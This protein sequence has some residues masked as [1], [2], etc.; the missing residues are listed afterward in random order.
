MRAVDADAQ[1]AVE[2]AG[3]RRRHRVIDEP[4][5]ESLAVAKHRGERLLEAPQ[6]G[7]GSLARAGRSTL[8]GTR[9]RSA[10]S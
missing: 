1:S 3:S 2:T 7:A 10:A 5:A 9:P 6:P 4:D 8:T